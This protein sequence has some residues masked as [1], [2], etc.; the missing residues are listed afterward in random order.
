MRQEPLS[1]KLVIPATPGFYALSLLLDEHD[2]VVGA[3]KDPIVGWAV[4]Q[5]NIVCAVTPDQIEVDAHATLNPD[6][7]VQDYTGSWETI[8][9]WVSAQ[10][11]KRAKLK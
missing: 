8:D 3:S 9:A 5:F 11:T 4:D 2:Q 10:R 1:F 6:G 7:T